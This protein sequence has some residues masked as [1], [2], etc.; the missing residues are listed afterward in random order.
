MKA[1]KDN[2]T[3]NV[4]AYIFLALG[5]ATF[6]LA[7]LPY[8]LYFSYDNQLQITLIVLATFI[9][10]GLS[11]FFSKNYNQETFSQYEFLFYTVTIGLI[12]HY[13]SYLNGPLI[14]MYGLVILSASYFLKLEYLNYISGIA[15]LFV[16]AEFFILV[17][18]GSLI[19]S[20]ISTI[21]LFLRILYLVLLTR[22][23]KSL[24]MGI[25][26][27]QKQFQQ[28]LKLNRELTEIDKLKRDFIDIASH[29]LKTPLT[30]IKGN[31]AMINDGDFG[32]IGNNLKMPL[33]EI[34]LGTR[35]LSTVIDDVVN[36]LKFEESIPLKLNLKV[37]NLRELVACEVESFLPNAWVR[38]VRLETKIEKG[39]ENFL[40]DQEKI[41]VALSIFIENAINRSL[42]G[43]TVKILVTKE[44]KAVSVK[45]IDASSGL[46]GKQLKNIL[47][48]KLQK[49]SKED[50]DRL[51]LNLYL[52][53]KIVESHN[54]HIIFENETQN[55]NVSGF[56]LPIKMIEKKKRQRIL[57]HA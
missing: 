27:Q 14:F 10:S 32:S 9:I 36:S 20:A 13:I 51:G 19:F 33:N 6:S 50:F 54:G 47:K 30:A 5:V 43:Q 2:I 37:T 56:T 8:L 42:R 17:S 26:A 28:L 12:I 31:V 55:G 21:Y 49:I 16:I 25:R 3:N 52:A 15:S 45:V 18:N 4:R 24:A 57:A 22:F 11:Y 40:L 38:D 7:V 53:Q 46:I 35:R 39:L 44:K 48:S 23:G 29:Q 34:D 1:G 41:K